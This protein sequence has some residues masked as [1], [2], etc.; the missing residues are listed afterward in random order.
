MKIFGA[1]G[2]FFV[3]RGLTPW[4]LACVFFLGWGAGLKAWD[5][6]FLPCWTD[7]RARFFE[8]PM[9]EGGRIKPLGSVARTSLLILS[10][11]ES[12]KS[13][14]EDFL[15]AEAFFLDLV[16]NPGQARKHPVFRVD[17]DQLK[18]FL[19][20]FEKYVSFEQLEPHL[21][22]LASRAEALPAD[23][24]LRDAFEAQLA[25]LVDSIELY[26]SLEGSILPQIQNLQGGDYESRFEAVVSSGVEALQ[27]QEAGT[28]YDE[29]ALSA[30]VALTHTLLDHAGGPEFALLPPELIGHSGADQGWVALPTLLLEGLFLKKRPEPLLLYWKVAQAYNE[31][32]ATSFAQ[33]VEALHDFFKNNLESSVF[34][35]IRVEQTFN[36][37]N[38]FY[39]A[40]VLY[41]AVFVL[42]GCFWLCP[43]KG[44]WRLGHIG[45]GVALGLH[46]LGLFVRMY[47]SG[48][49]P[50]TNLYSS[51]LFV[52]WTAAFLAWVLERSQ[53][54]GLMGAVGALLGF[55]TLWVAKAL[56]SSGDTLELLRAVLDTN[57]W[58]GTHVV[59]M[60][61]GY[62]AAF[63]AGTLS[64]FT[65]LRALLGRRRH[66][67]VALKKELASMERRVYGL[68]CF[69]LLLSFVGTLLGGIWAD[70]SW[71]RFWGWDPK[72]NG[73]LLIVL[74]L[75]LLLH[76]RWG[77]LI[78]A[79]AFLTLSIFCNVVTSWSWFGTNMLG[80]GLHTYGFTSSAFPYL[81]AFALSQLGIMCLASGLR[82]R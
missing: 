77:R 43:K 10:G 52:G 32:N 20:V 48:R 67:A 27:A 41:L 79:Q 30:L 28:A 3:L 68:V 72:E 23:P 12:V 7:A 62:G 18:R 25:K 35:K 56:G 74:W 13:A 70:Q 37:L 19:G 73:A 71:G 65:L 42:S 66:S 22:A 55:G 64:A 50:I 76:A 38:P 2:I 5:E 6:G 24:Q 1:R 53:R 36:R 33:H 75:A 78:D 57:F 39:W 11:R 21:E 82:R 51:A 26:R 15:S 81:I 8:L 34:L 69:A 17:H 46:T 45:L 63:V 80:V 47:V 4:A 9:Q 16:F 54:Q 14:R 58:L 40:R 44:V 31:H 61:L 60:N 29:E 59:M 49:P